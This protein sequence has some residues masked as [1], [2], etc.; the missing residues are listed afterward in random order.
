MADIC[1]LYCFQSAIMVD[2]HA[3]KKVFLKKRKFSQNVKVV[4]SQSTCSTGIRNRS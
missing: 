4:H 2:K 1:V 3:Q